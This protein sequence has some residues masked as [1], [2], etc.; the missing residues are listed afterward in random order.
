MSTRYGKVKYA[1]E[2]TKLFW[3]CAI[4]SIIIAVIM[5][6]V[7]IGAKKIGILND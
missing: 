6:A 2:T 7:A 5:T 4:I 3:W 1:N